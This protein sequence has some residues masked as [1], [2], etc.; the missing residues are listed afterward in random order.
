MIA[1]RGDA[2]QCRVSVAMETVFCERIMAEQ[3]SPDGALVIGA[4]AMPRIAAIM[5]LVVGVVG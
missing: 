3:P 5:R 4:V 2:L 1:H